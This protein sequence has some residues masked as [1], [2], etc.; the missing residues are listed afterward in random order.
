MLEVF[1]ASALNPERF[2]ATG[3]TDTIVFRPIA[4]G[5]PPPKYRLGFLSS[6]SHTV[7]VKASIGVSDATVRETGSDRQAEATVILARAC[8]VS[9]VAA[10][11]LAIASYV[12]GLSGA[13]YGAGLALLAAVFFGSAASDA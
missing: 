13:S 12:P 3:N 11:C 4:G 2:Q 6:A 5:S 1:A 10:V 8:G 7:S 9:F